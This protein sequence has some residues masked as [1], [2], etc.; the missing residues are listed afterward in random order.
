MFSKVQ[1]FQEDTLTQY[2]VRD[3]IRAFNSIVSI[4]AQIRQGELFKDDEIRSSFPPRREEKLKLR[5]SN[6][7]AYTVGRKRGQA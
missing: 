3:K 7:F 6:A 1:P 2:N 4:L 5:L